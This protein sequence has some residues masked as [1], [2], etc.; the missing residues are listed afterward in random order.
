M[1]FRVIRSS[2]PKVR[3]RETHLPLLDLDRLERECLLLIEPER[4]F[5]RLKVLKRLQPARRA[6][7]GERLARHLERMVDA[8]RG[9]LPRGKGRAGGGVAVDELPRCGREVRWAVE[10]RRVDNRAGG[11][12][13]V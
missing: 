12:P 8:R 9:A 6:R 2:S 3:P 10:R 7:L 11:S 1:I 13:M 5:E 4:L